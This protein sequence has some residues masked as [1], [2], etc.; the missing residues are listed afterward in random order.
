MGPPWRTGSS[1]RTAEGVR[2]QNPSDLALEVI[3]LKR[4]GAAPTPPRRTHVPFRQAL[5]ATD[6]GSRD[7]G[8]DRRAT[9][10][11]R[12]KIGPARIRRRYAVPAMPRRTGSAT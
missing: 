11:Q 12:A 2:W 10:P 6:A 3:G 9:G 8:N 1:L 7:R 4:P 5:C